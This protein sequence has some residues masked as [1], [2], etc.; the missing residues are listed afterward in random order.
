MFWCGA[1]EKIM[2]FQSGKCENEDVKM[3]V[4]ND[5]LLFFVAVKHDFGLLG[6]LKKSQQWYRPKFEPSL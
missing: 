1:S 3:L 5:L 4:S 2:K 6:T